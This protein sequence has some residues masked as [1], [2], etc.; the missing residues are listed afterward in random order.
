MR[1]WKNVFRR[2]LAGRTPT[3][4]KGWVLE[5]PIAGA[6]EWIEARLNLGRYDLSRHVHALE[7]A[8]V[9]CDQTVLI[10]AQMRPKPAG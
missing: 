3:I 2:K 8:F 6:K 1:H 5:K 7:K 10:D 9:F 4:G